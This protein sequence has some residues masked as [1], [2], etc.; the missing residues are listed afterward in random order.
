ML[1]KIL[2]LFSPENQIL[3]SKSLLNC[4]SKGVH[5]FV[6]HEYKDGRVLRMFLC[7]PD[8]E[9]W[10]NNCEVTLSEPHEL[11]VAIHPHHV[12]IEITP[13]FGYLW[14]LEFRKKKHHAFQKGQ[15]KFK[16][17]RWSSQI[18]TGNGGFEY[19]GEQ[20]LILEKFRMLHPDKKF[21]MK[22]NEL[23]TVYVTKWQTAAWLVDEKPA[24]SG[25]D[26]VNYSNADLTK[27]TPE[28]LY[29]KPL[30]EDIVEKMKL[31]GVNLKN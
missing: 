18:S 15:M 17:F 31:I 25:Y 9:L 8:H 10:K 28:G 4:H 2:H 14:N 22:S 1:E 12:D 20:Y 21:K 16:K 29:Q 11:S 13:V 24:S 6:L 30:W 7:E 23:H 19:L 27:W 3:L 5:Y 26:S